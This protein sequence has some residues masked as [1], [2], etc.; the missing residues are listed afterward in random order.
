MGVDA[1]IDALVEALVQAG[2]EAPRAPADSPPL[3]AIDDT[4]APMSLPPQLRRFWERID[5]RTLRVW[6]Y[7]QPTTP[8]FALDSWRSQR[9]EFPGIAPA[10]LLLVGYE[11][12]A[13][14]SVELD[15]PFSSGGS[16]FEWRLDDR[17]FYLRYHELSGWLDR[18]T[19]LIRAGE[20]ER[21]EGAD[22]AGL[23]LT[24]PHTALPLNALPAPAEPSPVHGHVTAYEGGPLHWPVHWQRL[25]GLAPEDIPPRGATHTIA[26]LLSSDRSREVRATIAGRVDG[27]AG[28]GAMMH[29]SVSDGTGTISVDCPAPVTMLGPAMGREFE[30]DVVVQTGPAAAVARAIRPL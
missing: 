15:T 25:S 4:I 21:H 10:A 27:L 1:S 6:A 20:F 24:D 2:V 8:E 18:M 5:P 9:A 12:H 7:P 23:R 16:V 28:V 11:S 17:G 26:E 29:A 14:M 3:A 19:E 13:C 30:F 22:G